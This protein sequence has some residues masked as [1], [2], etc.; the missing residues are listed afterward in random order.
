MKNLMLHSMIIPMISIY[1]HAL[2]A[3]VYAQD[4][5][6][7]NF[8]KQSL[9]LMQNPQEIL[10]ISDQTLI[11]LLNFPLDFNQT[12]QSDFQDCQKA[13]EQAIQK[14][15][16]IQAIQHQSANAQNRFST[17]NQA[18]S[19]RGRSNLINTNLQD[20]Q[21]L[22]AKAGIRLP[23]PTDVFERK[24]A[25][26]ARIASQH[27]Q[28]EAEKE[29]LQSL[30]YDLA[31]K[32]DQSFRL[33]LLK[34]LEIRYLTLKQKQIEAIFNEGFTEQREIEKIKL[35][36]ILLQDDWQA[37]INRFHMTQYDLEDLTNQKII[38]GRCQKIQEK[39]AKIKLIQAETEILKAERKAKESWQIDFLEI[40][41]QQQQLIHMGY[42]SMG[43]R[44]PWHDP[45][46]EDHLEIMAL[47]HE[48]RIEEEM[49]KKAM[50][51]AEIAKKAFR[52]RANEILEVNG[53]HPHRLD[54]Q[55]AWEWW[56]QMRERYFEGGYE[57]MK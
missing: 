5:S 8:Q 41:W 54:L 9:K 53:S 20:S 35:K 23:I 49:Q 21:Q 25:W 39:K 32:L 34:A 44:L 55:F 18:P 4:L 19:F 24:R 43:I 13:F 22:N 28:I 29:E 38:M 40:G 36:L 14:H 1:L 2:S 12:K 37:M 27:W 56:I 7:E 45:S 30:I 17:W 15:L 10:Q 16:Q 26:D 50:K 6:L 33:L 57:G 52:E 42:L 3:F 46:H 11:S 31:L 47:E 51:R 48:S